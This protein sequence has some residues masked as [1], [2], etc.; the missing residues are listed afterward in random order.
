MRIEEKI[1]QHLVKL[2]QKLDQ[3]IMSL[4]RG[5]PPESVLDKDD[6]TILK[7]HGLDSYIAHLREMR[8]SL[9][10]PEDLSGD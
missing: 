4:E 5:E 1:P 2:A 10:Q 9:S 7:R 3:Q 8:L 6:I